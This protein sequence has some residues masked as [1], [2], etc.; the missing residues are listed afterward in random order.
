VALRKKI[1]KL[2]ILTNFKIQHNGRQSWR[3]LQSREMQKD[4]KER[5]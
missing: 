2:K 5:K 3:T 4:G 1:W